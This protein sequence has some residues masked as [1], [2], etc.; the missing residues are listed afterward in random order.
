M[1][2]SH[3]V[4][5]EMVLHL[6]FMP[7]FLILHLQIV[8][9]TFATQSAFTDNMSSEEDIHDSDMNKSASTSLDD[10]EDITGAS[11]SPLTE[12]LGRERKREIFDKSVI[13]HE[14]DASSN[15]F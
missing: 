7:S 14:A 13:E 6:C 15:D 4:L 3:P 10:C 5:M 1:C 9:R 12:T 2:P 11:S 8:P